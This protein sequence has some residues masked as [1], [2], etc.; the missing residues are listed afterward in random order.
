MAEERIVVR[1]KITHRTTY[2]YADVVPVCH[3]LVHL[4]PRTLAHQLVEQSELDV[5]P[6]TSHRSRRIDYFGNTI[7]YL[8]IEQPHRRLSITARSTV[9]ILGPIARDEGLAIATENDPPWDKVAAQ[10]A[11]NRDSHWI[12]AYQYMLP[13]PRIIPSVEA[14]RYAKP[15][16]AA[17]RG[18]IDASCDLMRRIHED[19][20]FDDT[21]SNVLTPTAEVFRT[22]RGVCQDFA[23]LQIACLR[24][25]G[26]A[27]RY[28]SGYLRTYPP[29]GRPRLV[30][31]DASHAWV[32]LFVPPDRWIELDP[33]NN[34]QPSTDHIVVAYGRDFSDV[35]PI[36]GVFI[37]GGEHTLGVSVDVAPL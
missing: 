28:V 32:S 36:D 31:A 24:S 7:D 35:S 6:K 9:N 27:A 1:Y 11:T 16:F 3:N 10:V 14:V 15:S 18:I 5:E 22:R 29:P 20:E 21:A 34:A 30:G 13:S 25:L 37:G 12:Q 4:T 19:F 23:H 8:Q 17:G 26:L 33:T 2:D